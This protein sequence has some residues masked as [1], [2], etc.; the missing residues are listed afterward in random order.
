MWQIP[1]LVKSNSSS[2]SSTSS[3]PTFSSIP[4]VVPNAPTTTS[5]TAPFGF[6]LSTSLSKPFYQPGEEVLGTFSIF[7]DVSTHSASTNAAKSP[8]VTEDQCSINLQPDCQSHEHFEVSVQVHGHVFASEDVLNAFLPRP[9]ETVAAEEDRANSCNTESNTYMKG[10]HHNNMSSQAEAHFAQITKNDRSRNKGLGIS[11]EDEKKRDMLFF[12]KDHGGVCILR[13]Q[14][15]K[16]AEWTTI[17]ELTTAAII[18]ESNDVH[19]SCHN[20]RSDLMDDCAQSSVNFSCRL[21]LHILPSFSSSGRPHGIDIWYCV[22]LS[23]TKQSYISATPNQAMTT[24]NNNESITTSLIDKGEAMVRKITRFCHVPF[25]VQPPCLHSLQRCSAS[26]SEH[27]IALPTK[28]VPCGFIQ[29]RTH[30]QIIFQKYD[31]EVGQCHKQQIK[32][33]QHLDGGRRN[34]EALQWN[35][36]GIRES[37]RRHG[38]DP[39]SL[40]QFHAPLSGQNIKVR[41]LLRWDGLYDKPGINNN[42]EQW[43]LNSTVSRS[44]QGIYK[45]NNW[46]VCT[47]QIKNA[48]GLV[49]ALT[50]TADSVVAGDTIEI[51]LDRTH[52][53]VPCF[54]ICARLVCKRYWRSKNNVTTNKQN[55]ANLG[56]S[57]PPNLN[58]Q[59]ENNFGKTV[60]SKTV[61][62]VCVDLQCGILHKALRLSVPTHANHSFRTRLVAVEWALEFEFVCLA[63][64][65]LDNR[66]KADAANAKDS[67]KDWPTLLVG[68]DMPVSMLGGH[69]QSQAN[70]TSHV[71]SGLDIMSQKIR[72]RGYEL[73]QSEEAAL[74]TIKWKLPIYVHAS[75]PDQ[76]QPVDHR[77][78]GSV[79]S[80]GWNIRADHC[81]S[82]ALLAMDASLSEH[83]F[84]ES[85]SKSVKL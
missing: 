27:L 63:R 9:L 66:H 1:S 69:K 40:A 12:S 8:I 21:P 59:Q 72:S 45:K 7:R 53:I 77:S 64:K 3:Y 29:H 58:W 19:G 26:L 79:C 25:G 71:A 42:K 48:Q 61:S 39:K 85:I 31:P 62:K 60:E 10:N 68:G 6:I 49:V 35:T 38:S 37:S 54:S 4:D 18:S 46:G 81:H 83:V 30:R 32:S 5:H 74:K 75:L 20:M 84:V 24:I 70:G 67:D 22:T 23:I 73:S 11:N 76:R 16:V 65:S 34:F 52:S 44:D 57:H 36:V 28:I 55:M 43:K 80:N 41:H 2:S 47:Y 50:I 51:A 56:E 82:V 15:T 13:S 78:L 17:G 14:I 33:S